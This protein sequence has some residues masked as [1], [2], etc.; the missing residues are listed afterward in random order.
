MSGNVPWEEP[1][2]FTTEELDE[3][4]ASLSPEGREFGEEVT[5]AYRQRLVI[6]KLILEAK[7]LINPLIDTALAVLENQPTA[8]VEQYFHELHLVIEPEKLP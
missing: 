1:T 7:K 8:V 4:L 6:D 5:K 3:W 2:N